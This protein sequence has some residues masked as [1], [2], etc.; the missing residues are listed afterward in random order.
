MRGQRT[1]VGLAHTMGA[2][3]AHLLPGPLGLGQRRLDFLDAKLE[4][5]GIELLG[6]AAETV[7]LQGLD[8]RPQAL[9][10]GLK[11]LERVEFT[12][13]FENE[14]AQRVNIV[15]KVGFHEHGH[16]ESASQ[17]RVK[18]QVAGL[19]GGVRH[20]PAAS[21]NPP[22]VRPVAPPSAASRRSGCPAT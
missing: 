14:Q 20:A 19:L 15:G 10:F 17:L 4:L 21:P 6:T 13:L 16:T 3:T 8:D 9:D 5:I 7:T 18:P 1:A 11:D 2:G 22:E 12:G